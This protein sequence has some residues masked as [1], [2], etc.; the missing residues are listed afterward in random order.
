MFESS[1]FCKFTKFYVLQCASSLSTKSIYHNFILPA[2]YIVNICNHLFLLLP[3]NDITLPTN[4]S[5]HYHITFS[6]ILLNH[7]RFILLN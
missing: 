4:N 3:Y 5:Y 6:N 1:D 7:H 2:K